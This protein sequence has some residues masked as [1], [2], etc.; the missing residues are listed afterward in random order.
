MVNFGQ[1]GQEKIQQFGIRWNVTDCSLDIAI[2]P[3]LFY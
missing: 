2:K 3:G 1:Q